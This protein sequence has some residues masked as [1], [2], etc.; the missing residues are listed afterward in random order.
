MER[1]DEVMSGFVTENGARYFVDSRHRVFSGGGFER[2]KF[3]HISAIIGCNGKIEL[4]DG[5]VITTG[6]IVK[7]V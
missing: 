4:P 7:Y 6:P 3:L 1:S 2:T 5:K